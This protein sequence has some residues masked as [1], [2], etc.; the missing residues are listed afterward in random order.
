V[1][2]YPL[3]AWPGCHRDV[4]HVYGHVHGALPGTSQSCDVG[5]DCWAYAPA[6]AE[7][8]IARMA[9]TP[10]LPE[11]RWRARDDEADAE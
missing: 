8:V 10:D 11:E 7:D 1:D 9:A 5:V 4:L 3:R 6:R 2:H